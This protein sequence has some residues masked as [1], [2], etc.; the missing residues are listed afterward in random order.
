L[1]T[2]V[3]FLS[4]KSKGTGSL[5]GSLIGIVLLLPKSMPP[6]YHDLVVVLLLLEP[7]IKMQFDMTVFAFS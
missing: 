4:T 1:L 6:F 3:I 7:K 5:F 2:M